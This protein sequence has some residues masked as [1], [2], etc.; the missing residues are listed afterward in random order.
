MV[1][2]Q[3]FVDPAKRAAISIGEFAWEMRS[4]IAGVSLAEASGATAELERADVAVGVIVN[5]VPSY[6]LRRVK[7]KESVTPHRFFFSSFFFAERVLA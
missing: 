5:G 1:W 7:K 4:Q 3:S 6:E 2:F